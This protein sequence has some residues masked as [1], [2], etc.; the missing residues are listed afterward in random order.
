MIKIIKKDG[1]QEDFNVNKVVV[2]IQKS[3]GRALVILS[4]YEI[5][6]V[7]KYVK[8]KAELMA[9][10]V[11]D[12]DIK[13]IDIP[14]MHFIVESVLDTINAE[15]AKSYRDYRNYKQD[16]YKMI[17]NVYKKV[18]SIDFI[19]DRS[20]ANTDSTLVSTKRCLGWNELNGEFYKKFFINAEERQ[21]MKEGYI[22]IHDRSARLDTYNCC[23]FDVATVFKGGFELGNIKY[24][25]PTTLAIAFNVLGDVVMASASQQYGGWTAPEM[26]KILEP[27]AQKSYKKFVKEYEEIVKSLGEVKLSPEEFARRADDYATHKVQRDFEQGFQ[28]LEYKLNTVGSSRGDYP[29]VTFTFGLG[30]GKFEKMA[31]LAMLK[32]RKGGQGAPG[33]KKAVLFPKLV[34]LYD[35][36]IHGK[37]K[38][39]EDL[40]D[41]AIDCSSVAQY[42]DYLSMSGKGY[43]ASMYKEY[44]KPISPMGCRAFLS[45]YW[46]RGG[47][48]KADEN[49]VP[50]FVGRFN[51]GAISL[52]LPMIFMKA[53][54]EGKDFYEVYKHYLEMIRHL[55]IKTRDYLA[56]IKASKSPL[57]FM[58]GGLY[59]G[60]LKPDE[61]IKPLL[62]YV[63]F[64]FGYTALNELQRLYNGKS[65]IEDG[66]FAMEVMQYLNDYVARIKEEDHI[67]YAIYGTPAESLISLQVQQFRDKYGIIEGVSDKEYFTNSFHC[68]VSEDISPIEKQDFE[69]RFW[70]L[71]NGGKITYTRYPIDY[72]LEAFK[73]VVRRGMAKGFYQGINMEKCYCEDCGYEQLEMQ[74]CPKCGSENITEVDRVCGYLGYSRVN[75]RSFMNDG[76]LA[77][78]KDRKSM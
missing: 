9:T 32:V 1:T 48:H 75:G 64:S 33:F 61:T 54:T 77:E 28:A 2:A 42:P 6:K 72:N 12:G 70:E 5:Q 29:F 16:F 38:C 68:H 15:V 26:D 50:V 51:G 71:S 73:T 65:I 49:D 20:N 35:E 74:K 13:I 25:E 52:N 7:K 37:G 59:R 24:T 36:S 23:L 47:Q 67:L 19:G 11:N 45:P 60:H 63:T 10:P 76:K 78:I 18:Q 53:K 27:Y 17:D 57:A 8:E 4:D 31:T 34:F 55:H 40:F 39:C 62:D 46:E 22:Y 41:A 69:E 58:E 66:A 21:A 56:K 14:T 44:G 43:I 3:A 30:Q